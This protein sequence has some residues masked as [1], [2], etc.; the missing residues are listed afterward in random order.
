MRLTGL[1]IKNKME[2]PKADSLRSIK[3]CS[4]HPYKMWVMDS[5]YLKPFVKGDTANVQTL[6]YQLFPKPLTSQYYLYILIGV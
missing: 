3:L 2:H 5:G 4:E 1:K 6:S